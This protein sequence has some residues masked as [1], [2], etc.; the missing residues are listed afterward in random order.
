MV[1]QTEL[2]C[3]CIDDDSKDTMLASK[4]G[5]DYSFKRKIVWTN[6]VIFLL[7]HLLALYGFY[8]SLYC[9]FATFVW[10]KTFKIL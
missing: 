6:A 4:I 8:L 2:I 7:F 9:K 1:T 3:P 5:T 10:S